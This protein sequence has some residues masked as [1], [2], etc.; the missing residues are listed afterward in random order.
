MASFNK[1]IIVGHLGR[2]QETRYTP[3]GTAVSNSALRRPSVERTRVVSSRI[4]PPGS[5]FRSGENRQRILGSICSRGVRSM[6]REG[7]GRRSTPTAKE[8]RECHSKSQRQMFNCLAQRV[9]ARWVAHRLA[10][11]VQPEVVPVT[12]L[13]M[14]PR[15]E[16]PLGSRAGQRMTSLFNHLR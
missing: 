16:D 9:R 6:S 13:T 3:Q 1:I 8:I 11:E 10:E 2:D 7:S 14:S 4:S 5:E 12:D 15:P